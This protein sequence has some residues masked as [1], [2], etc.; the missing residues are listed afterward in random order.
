MR[1]LYTNTSDAHAPDNYIGTKYG[2]TTF[3]QENISKHECH[4]KKSFL[5]VAAYER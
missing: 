2:D 1:T 4:K 3:D 5:C